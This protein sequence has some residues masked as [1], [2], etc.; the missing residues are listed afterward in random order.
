MI[1]VIALAGAK[2]DMFGEEE[3]SEE[4]AKK[5]AEKINALLQM[6][7][8]KNNSGIDE[9]FELIAKKVDEREFVSSNLKKYLSY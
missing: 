4:E 5:F 9:L 1:L 6:T 7:S 3:V 8:A 2:S